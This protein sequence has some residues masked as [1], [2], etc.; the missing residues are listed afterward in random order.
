MPKTLA[1]ATD[2][3]GG[4]YLRWEDC[5]PCGFGC[6]VQEFSFGRAKL[7]TFVKYLSRDAECEGGWV[8]SELEVG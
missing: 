5:D 4:C 3:W 7:E 8:N 2:R 1:R 6:A